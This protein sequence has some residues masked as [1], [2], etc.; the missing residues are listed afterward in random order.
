MDTLGIEPRAFCMRS[1]CTHPSNGHTSPTLRK[2]GRDDLEH[3][4]EQ[5]HLSRI[6]VEKPPK[7][8]RPA[9]SR[10][11]CPPGPC[12]NSGT[13][14][15]DTR[16][17]NSTAETLSVEGAGGRKKSFSSQ[18]TCSM[19]CMD[20]LG[21]EPRACCMRSGCTH[22]SNGHTSPTLRKLGR[23]D[24][25]H[26]FEQEHLSRIGVEK[27]PKSSRPAFSRVYCP[28]GPC[29]NSGTDRQ[30]TRPTNSTAETLSVEGA[31]GRKKSFSSQRTCSML[32]MDTLGIEPRACQPLHHSHVS[33]S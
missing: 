23:D 16:P 30:D 31:G 22:P 4:F 24:L 29:A 26:F 33:F 11:Y 20:T 18:L 7:S 6:G 32:C 27:P 3:F 14:R 17:T 25:E 19:P 5:E 15:Q 1:G 21:I 9:F 12:A 10:V 2:W 28:P 13:D 8:C